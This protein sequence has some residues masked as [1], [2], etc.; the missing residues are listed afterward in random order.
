MSQLN[1][2]NIDR[3]L[4]ILIGLT[5]VGLA[6]IGAIDAWGFIGIVPLVTGVIGM[7]PLYKLLGFATTSR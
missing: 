4:R 6:A 3:T 7:C 1:V 2:G 5:L